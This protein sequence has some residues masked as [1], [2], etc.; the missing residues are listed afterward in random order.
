MIVLGVHLVKP[1]K[2]LRSL[3][4]V[5]RWHQRSE[6]ELFC[7]GTRWRSARLVCIAC[8]M[9]GFWKGKH[10]E[11]INTFAVE[12]SL[13]EGNPPLKTP[14]YRW[15]KCVIILQVAVCGRRRSSWTFQLSAKAPGKIDIP[16]EIFQPLNIEEW[17]HFCKANRIGSWK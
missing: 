13:L 2:V 1:P 11:K 4:G 8:G 14:I 16:K 15:L 9:A 10:M 17:M 7:V 5:G 6:H 3:F 12:N